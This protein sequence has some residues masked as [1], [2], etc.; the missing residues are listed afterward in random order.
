MQ[1]NKPEAA[2]FLDEGNAPIRFW[3]SQP[4]SLPIIKLQP[5]QWQRQAHMAEH[6]MWVEHVTKKD[7]T[8]E[9]HPA[10]GAT[11]TPQRDYGRSAMVEQ[12]R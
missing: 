10:H 7:A 5:L 8:P 6:G 3:A 2:L 1:I 9:I 12:A 11:F 4:V